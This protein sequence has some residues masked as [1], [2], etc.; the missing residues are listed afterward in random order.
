MQKFFAP[1]YVTVGQPSTLRMR[2]VSSFDPNAPTPLT[3][4]GV[5]YTDTLPNGVFI[6]APAN[7]GPTCAGTGP[8]GL[9]VVSTSANAV[10]LTQAIIVPGTTCSIFTDVV[11]GALG[12]YNNTIPVNAVTTDQGIPNSTAANATLFVVATP[13]VSQGLRTGDGQPGRLLGADDHD[14][15]R[16]VDPADRRVARRHASR[17]V[18]RSLRR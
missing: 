15:E 5:T 17:R 9:A 3:L 11:A 10:T 8:G 12:A 1:A 4:T 2:L 14:H 6:N 7:A 18:S 16:R 13:T